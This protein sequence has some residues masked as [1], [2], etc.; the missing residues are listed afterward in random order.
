VTTKECRTC[1]TKKPLDDYYNRKD[2]KDGKFSECKDCHN[3]RRNRWLKT[4]KGKAYRRRKS[5]ERYDKKKH[6]EVWLEKRRAK[7]RA[8]YANNRDKKL[9][10]VKEY[11]QKK[12]PP[13]PRKKSL[14]SFVAKNPSAWYNIIFSLFQLLEEIHANSSNEKVLERA[15]VLSDLM[16][17]ANFSTLQEFCEKCK[18][19]RSSKTRKTKS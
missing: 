7:D 15:V 3:Q 16:R 12:G 14:A 11:Q 19:P 10:S 18:D 6:D 1:S 8:W 17:Y 9:A 13:K 2:A 4:D 5:K